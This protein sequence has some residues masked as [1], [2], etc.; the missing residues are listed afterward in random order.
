M[1][2]ATA[3]KAALRIAAAAARQAA[4][5]AH[6]AAAAIAVRDIFLAAIPLVPSAT[7]SGYWPIAAELDVRPLLAALDALGHVCA[8]PAVE[9]RGRPLVFRRWRPGD[10][11]VPAG[12]GLSMPRPEAAPVEPDLLIVPLL[13]FD[14]RGYRLGYGGGYYDRTLALWRARKAVLAVGVAF[15]AQEVPA[16]PGLT[17]DQRLDWIVTETGARQFAPRRPTER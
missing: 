9:A 3:A 8:L 2:D 5:A 11:L 1:P 16:V 6:G 10:E 15:G 17:G 7:I 13:A 12:F 4:H 14:A